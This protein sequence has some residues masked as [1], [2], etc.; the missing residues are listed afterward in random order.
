[1]FSNKTIFEMPTKLRRALGD[2]QPAQLFKQ[3]MQLKGKAFRDVPGRK[4][5]QVQIGQET[6]FVKQHEGIGWGEIL[7]NL[8]SFKKPVLGAMTEVQAIQQVSN[9]GVSTTPL[10]AYGQQGA[11]P[12]NLQSFLITEDLGDIVSLEDFCAEWS[13]N[14]PDST[15]KNLLVKHLAELSAT[16]HGAGLCHRDYYL[17]HIVLQKSD[18]IAGKLNLT[19]IDLHRTLFNQPSDGTTVMKDIAALVFSARD[20][21][22][23]EADWALFKTHYLPQSDDF[24]KKVFI[25]ADKLYAKFNSEKF[26][27]RLA[28]EKAK[29]D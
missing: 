21:G 6:Y 12:A 7:K 10:V 17:C 18:F 2:G 29:L 13:S 3:V 9:L 14:P 20:V 11:N 15:F 24:W 22:F 19:V 23:D 8:L 16:L 1:M 27:A 5:S 4:T 26:Q 25:R 28:A